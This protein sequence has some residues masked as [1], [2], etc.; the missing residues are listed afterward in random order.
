MET[1]K[2]HGTE[3]TPTVVLDNDQNN[4]EMHGRCFPENANVFFK[5]ILTWL[6][7]YASQP[8]ATTNFVINLQYYNTA[9]SKFLLEM[10][11]RLDLIHQSGA[12][13]SVT[14]CYD[15]E[16]EDMEEA[17]EEYADLLNLPFRFVV[18]N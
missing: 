16:D 9:T 2:I 1:I 12:N 11:H 3:A 5:P 17:G 15:E 14:W 7:S 4:F 18:N 6:D 8:N 10:L 13:T